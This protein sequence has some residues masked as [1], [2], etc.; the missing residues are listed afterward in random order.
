[1]FRAP[2]CRRGACECAA[3]KLQTRCSSCVRDAYGMKRSF[4]IAS[5]GNVL[6]GWVRFAGCYLPDPDTAP[7]AR[8][9]LVLFGQCFGALVQP[10]FLN[11]PAKLAGRTIISICNALFHINS[12]VWFPPKQRE[13]ATS[14]ASLANPV[15][16]AAGSVIPAL[17]VVDPNDMWQSL[18]TL[19]VLA[20]V[21]LLLGFIFYRDAY[22]GRATAM[23]RPADYSRPP[24]CFTTLTSSTAFVTT[25]SILPHPMTDTLCLCFLPYVAIPLGRAP[26]MPQ[27]P[28][29][30]TQ[31]LGQSAPYPPHGV[32]IRPANT[33]SIA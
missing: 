13:I 12:G 2:Y 33:N 26:C 10:L 7:Y 22:V 23:F 25:F 20:S 31:P 14:L 21:G 15:G 5:I 9:G 18:L 27:Q 11:V 19:A 3:A 6:C 28:A 16:N 4:L 17:L 30:P 29:D 24:Q 32:L 8:Y 1:M